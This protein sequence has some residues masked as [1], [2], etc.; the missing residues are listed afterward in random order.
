[1]IPLPTLPAADA[2]VSPCRPPGPAAGDD[3]CAPLLLDDG[4]RLSVTPLRPRDAAATQ[5]FVTALSAGS[6]YRRFHVGIPRLPPALLAHL[7]DID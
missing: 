2:R 7:V 3:P 4:R 1:M 5:A 6:R